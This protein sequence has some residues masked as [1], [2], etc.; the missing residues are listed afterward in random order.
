M[1]D[2]KNIWQFDY[3]QLVAVILV[4]FISWGLN[5]ISVIPIKAE[6]ISGDQ[7]KVVLQAELAT[8]QPSL[9]IQTENQWLARFQ[10]STESIDP[11]AVN[12][13][14][15][16]LNGTLSSQI[17]RY[18]TLY[19]LTVSV[20]GNTDLSWKGETWIYEGG[21]IKQEVLFDESLKVSFA[22]P[23]QLDIHMDLRGQYQE[24]VGLWLGSIITDAMV[25]GL[26]VESKLLQVQE[27]I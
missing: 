11:I 17:F 25:N 3:F 9:I 26:P 4:G 27:R 13:F 18:P 2:K 20:Y 19:P 24:R 16:Y 21:Y 12:G 6:Q 7:S 5:S 23:I 14:L 1:T 22:N 15:F 8:T 10:L